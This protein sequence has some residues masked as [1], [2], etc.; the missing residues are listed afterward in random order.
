MAKF[1]A[2]HPTLLEIREALRCLPEAHEVETWGHPTFRVRGKI[3][4][5]FGTTAR[6]ATI[7]NGL[8]MLHAQ[9]EASWRVWGASTR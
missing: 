8:K 5:G 6:G 4:G 7:T 2:N 1:D 9:A 3:F